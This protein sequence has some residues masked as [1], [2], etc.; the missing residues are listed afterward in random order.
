MIGVENDLPDWSSTGAALQ[1]TRNIIAYTRS[2]LV[3]YCPIDL[4]QEYVLVDQ[5]N[6]HAEP[7]FAID[8][9][10]LSRWANEN[11]ILLVEYRDG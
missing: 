5:V 1:Y 10:T 3:F 2:E 8:L 7:V 11:R 6:R 9:P 4:S